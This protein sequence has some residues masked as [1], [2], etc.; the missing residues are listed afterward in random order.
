MHLGVLSFFEEHF[1]LQREIYY[2]SPVPKNGADPNLE[3]IMISAAW[4]P[5]ERAKYGLK[6]RLFEMRVNCY[7]MS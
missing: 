1:R 6:S 4:L 2:V 3:N 7:I 5:D